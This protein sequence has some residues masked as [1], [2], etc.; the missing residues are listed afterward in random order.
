MITL[1]RLDLVLRSP[2]G[3]TAPEVPAADDGFYVPV[4][5]DAWG[6]PHVPATSLAGSL[7]ACA[8]DLGQDTTTLF[9]TV[10][11]DAVASP[12]RFL[13]TR[14]TIPEGSTHVRTRTAID[15]HRA[16]PVPGLLFSGE[17]LPAGTSITC[18][19]RLDDKALLDEL[20]SVLG[21][22]EPYIGGGRSVG[23]GR[24]ELTGV[25]MRQLDLNTAAG[26]AAWLTGGGPSLFA[27]AMVEFDLGPRSAPA[28]ETLA[29]TF[30]IDGGL[31][32]GT[33]KRDED[34]DAS[35]PALLIRRDGLPCVP[36]S[37]WK[38]L[39]R[40]RCEYI[41]RSIGRHACHSSD[42]ATRCSALPVC[43]VCAA[44][45]W[46]G[47][48]TYSVGQRSLLWFG[49]SLIT[50]GECAI[51]QHVALDRV[52]GGARDGQL[53]TLEVVTSGTV[54]LNLEVHGALTPAVR[55]LL[56]LAVA[57]IHD[58]HLGVGAATTRGLGRLLLSNDDTKSSREQ[59]ARILAEEIG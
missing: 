54:V 20:R 43:D 51:V 55:A 10:D 31:H 39:L 18:Y 13:G 11:G 7:R 47:E 15:R 30:T 46:T 50:D 52:T 6:D 16:A 3:V 59:A 33:G 34:A 1:L 40:S 25:R 53:Y 24:A 56:D 22:W 45:G 23:R 38:G 44:F 41:L 36:G 19:L 4:A 21:A 29:W 14:V 42:P 27:D 17:S 32:V 26:R 49:D 35:S 8:A 9:G 2:G 58:G 5:R 12:L 48:N 28:T 57:D 37:T